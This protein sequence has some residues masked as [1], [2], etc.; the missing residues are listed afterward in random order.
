MEYKVK[1]YINNSD[2]T[3]RFVLGCDNSNPLIVIGV[4]P[5]T[6]DEKNPDA[7]IRRVMGYMQRNCFNGFLML[8]VYAFRTTNPDCLPRE[9]NNLLHKQ[10]LEHIEEVLKSYPNATLLIAFGDTI[11]KRAYLKECFREIVEVA[12]KYNPK[13]KQIGNS[14]AKG[15]PRHP[16]RGSYQA[17]SELD[18]LKYIK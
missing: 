18:I 14:T 13:W 8:N 15:N 11:L 17:L 6:A 9:C 2:N 12:L 1:T 4:N 7:T 5:S 10:N 16:S 3:A